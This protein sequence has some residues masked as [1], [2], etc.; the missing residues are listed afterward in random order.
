[1]NSTVDSL[2]EIIETAGNKGCDLIDMASHG[3]KGASA[4]VL[5][6][7]TVKVLTHS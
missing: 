3:K 4:P 6:G 2:S 7:E 5:G 1:V